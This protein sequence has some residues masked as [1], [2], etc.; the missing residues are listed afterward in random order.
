MKSSDASAHHKHES[1]A[2]SDDVG[3]AM[4]TAEFYDNFDVDKFDVD[5]DFF[6]DVGRVSKYKVLEN[7][8]DK[9]D[10][11]NS[12]GNHKITL[13]VKAEVRRLRSRLK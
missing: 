5:D 8:I 3:S 7:A 6:K 11:L 1:A 13:E 4:S 2:D 10:Q 12:L 9:L